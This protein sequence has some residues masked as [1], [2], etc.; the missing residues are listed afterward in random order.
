M[1]F[2]HYGAELNKLGTASC[3]G[4]I[5]TTIINLKMSHKQQLDQMFACLSYFNVEVNILSLQALA[6]N[7]SSTR[8]PIRYFYLASCNSR[9]VWLHLPLLSQQAVNKSAPTVNYSNPG[10]SKYNI[11]NPD[12]KVR[13]ANIGPIWGRQ[14]PDGPHVGPMNFA[15]WEVLPWLLHKHPITSTP[16]NFHQ[17]C[18][19]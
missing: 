12:S 4:A 11:T 14:D 10:M 6:D 5:T 19:R 7:W 9:D 8:I 16:D 18:K 1:D 13:G 3:W 2:Q 17:N 15:L